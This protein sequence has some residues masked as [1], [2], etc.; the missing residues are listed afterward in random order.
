[1][2]WNQVV[3]QKSS[4]SLKKRKAESHFSLPIMDRASPSTVKDDLFSPTR[5]DKEHGSGLGLAICKQLAE[6]M[7]GGIFLKS[8]TS[9]GSTFCVEIQPNR[10][11]VNKFVLF[12]QIM[13][14]KACLSSFPVTA[15]LG[16]SLPCS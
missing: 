10:R 7:N 14:T 12:S 16:F 4:C 1:M 9:K 3:I 13:L 2:H 8:S 5:S 6:Q 11:P 15:K